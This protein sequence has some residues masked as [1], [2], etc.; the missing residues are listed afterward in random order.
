MPS[1]TADTSP[2]VPDNPPSLCLYSNLRSAVG[3]RQ[4]RS[5]EAVCQAALTFFGIFLLLSLSIEAKGLLLDGAS[6]GFARVV[7]HCRTACVVFYFYTPLHAARPKQLRR[8]FTGI[9]LFY[10]RPAAIPQQ[11]RVPCRPSGEP[12]PPSHLAPPNRKEQKKRRR[13]KIVCRS[14]SRARYSYSSIPSTSPDA[15]S[16]FSSHIRP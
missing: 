14:R 5:R 13:K 1:R 3:L 6:S 9:T 8:A 15:C 16:H 7:M 12:Q 11:P 2:R 10:P 4:H